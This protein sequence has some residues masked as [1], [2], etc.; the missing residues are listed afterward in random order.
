MRRCSVEEFVEKARKKFGDQFDYSQSIYI[1]TKTKLS[2]ICRQHGNF[3]QTPDGHLSKHNKNGC[4]QCRLDYLSN[5]NKNRDY[6]HRIYKTLPKEE[7]ESRVKDKFNSKINLNLENY[8][9]LTKNA[10][11]ASCADHGLFTTIPEY[12]LNSS[13]QFGCPNCARGSSISKRTLPYKEVEDKF[14]L[15]FD[16]KYSYPDTNNLTYINKSSIIK[17]ECPDHGIF[18]RSAQKHSEGRGCHKCK[19]EDL[20]SKNQM[21]GG[22]TK[23]FFIRNPEKVNSPAII[24]FLKINSGRYYKIGITRKNIL[25]RIKSIRSKAK[26]YNEALE[27]DIIFSQE[28]ELEK[29]FRLEQ[30]ALEIYREFRVFR[31]WSTELF[32]QDISLE[33]K[34]MFPAFL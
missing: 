30:S 34:D 15:L 10:I 7:L 13:T 23:D 32:H 25:N 33:I 6:S 26:K 9:G 29:C 11:Q 22:Y 28:G 16:N 3:M 19:I 14:N 5:L 8:N 27:I 18:T 31:R 17:I 12:L 21:V 4:P 20:I 1:D 2:I 24:Y